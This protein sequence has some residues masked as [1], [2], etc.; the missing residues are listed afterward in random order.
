LASRDSWL[1][2]GCLPWLTLGVRRST[3]TAQTCN[4]AVKRLSWPYG[5]IFFGLVIPGVMERGS[6]ALESWIRPTALSIGASLIRRTPG[7]AVSEA[8][9]AFAASDCNGWARA[10]GLAQGR[11][12]RR[13]KASGWSAFHSVRGGSGLE[14]HPFAPGAAMRRF[15]GA[16]AV[17]YRLL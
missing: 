15:L 1:S 2:G 12:R 14:C 7:I 16:K 6:R 4:A 11:E 17:S 9:L 10:W 3:M 13:T 8:F 5:A